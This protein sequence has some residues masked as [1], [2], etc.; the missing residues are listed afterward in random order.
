MTGTRREVNEERLFRSDRFLLAD[1]GDRPLRHRFGE[2]PLRVGVRRLDGRGVLVE[3]RVPLT[4]LS[5]LEAVPVVE[6]FSNRPAIERTSGA[7]LVVGCVVPFPEGGSA[8]LIT[9]KNL[10]DT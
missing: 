6:S 10:G 9:A 3:R 8:V 7:K 5:T 4:C 2:M 1:P